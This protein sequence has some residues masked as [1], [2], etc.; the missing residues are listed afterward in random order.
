ME[1][2]IDR[3]SESP[4]E[5]L[6][7]AIQK[8]GR[9][10]QGSLHLLERSGL[11][12]EFQS[13]V[14]VSQCTN[15]PLDLLSVRDD[16]IPQYVANGVSDLGIVGENVLCESESA[17][18]VEILERLGFARCKLAIAVPR[19]AGLD[20]M[21]RLEGKRIATS[22]PATL[23]RFLKSRGI[24]AEIV[25]LSG[26]VEI[27]TGLGLADAICDLVSTGSTARLNGLEFLCPVMESEAVLIINKERAR[28]TRQDPNDLIEKL[29]LRIRATEQAQKLKYV[30]MNAPTSA[31][32]LIRDWIPGLRSPSIVP[33]A[34]QDMVAVHSVVSED[35]L[36]DV[37]SKLKEVGASGIVALSVDSLIP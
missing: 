18:G 37:I 1:R 11:I 16:D 31:I 20:S 9:M 25:Q 21:E 27:A 17:D 2:Q 13:R 33:L 28:R 3:P 30:M 35:V 12:I 22:Y 6:K 36:W 8:D 14:L 10:T 26:A 15:F 5:K 34:N 23:G 19:A 32:P 7:L 29:M 24:R 4:K